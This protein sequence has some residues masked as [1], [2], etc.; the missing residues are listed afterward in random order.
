MQVKLL[1][2]YPQCMRNSPDLW[3]TSACQISV[4]IQSSL[5]SI[6]RTVSHFQYRIFLWGIWMCF[7]NILQVQG[8]LKGDMYHFGVGVEGRK[9]GILM[10]YL[11]TYV[12]QLLVNR[13]NNK[14]KIC[15]SKRKKK[16][17]WF[18]TH[19]FLWPEM[20]SQFN[21]HKAFQNE[22]VQRCSKFL[23]GNSLK[24]KKLL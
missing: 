9:Q 5:K 2:F 23:G 19:I 21:A 18:R 10:W 15:L 20:I 17:I 7:E 8:T 1:S 4:N 24:Y 11:K 12:Q 6:N 3:K 16:K 13:Q 14:R 22:G